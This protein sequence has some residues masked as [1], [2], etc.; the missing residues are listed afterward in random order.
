GSWRGTARLLLRLLS[1][2]KLDETEG[3]AF[4]LWGPVRHVSSPAEVSQL[5]K[6]IVSAEGRA[7]DAL[8]EA[9]GRVEWNAS[10]ASWQRLARRG[11]CTALAKI[12]EVLGA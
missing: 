6:L 9:L 10:A 1:A 12:A 4:A 5:E 2:A 3:L 7:R 8:L 11:S